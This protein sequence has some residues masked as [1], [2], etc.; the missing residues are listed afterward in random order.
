M[1]L[2]PVTTDRDRLIVLVGPP[3][4]G[5][6][7][8]AKRLVERYRIPQLAT[9]DMLRAARA[10]G[11]EL[12]KRVAA[13]MDAGGL[14]SDEIVIALIQERLA[15]P[16]TKQGAIFDGFPRTPAQAEALD[17]MLAKLGRKIDRVVIVEVPDGEVETRNVGRRM[18]SGCQRTYHLEFSPPSKPGIC[19]ACGGDLV[20]RPDD[21]LERIK[22]RLQ[23]YHRDTAPVAGYYEKK[24]LVRRVN[25]VG[26]LEEVFDRLATAIDA[27]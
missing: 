5:K 1:S 14:V 10:S 13:I 7:T 27:A 23:A 21:Q 11:N 8:Q 2:S 15:Q 6:G 3:G 12:G 17:S 16:E 19:D 4:A 26:G 18:C 20:Q 24:G 9:G 25:G 22:A